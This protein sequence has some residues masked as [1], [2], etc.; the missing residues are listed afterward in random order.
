MPTTRAVARAVGGMIS[1]PGYVAQAPL[2]GGPWST[3][4]NIIEPR[5]LHFILR[6]VVLTHGEIHLPSL[7]FVRA[8][9]ARFSQYRA[10][11]EMIDQLDAFHFFVCIA[12]R[13]LLAI[14]CAYA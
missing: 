1:R 12:A 7:S 3:Q 14:D 8:R 2:M 9:V 6:S 11:V 4:D 13:L 10:C 5:P